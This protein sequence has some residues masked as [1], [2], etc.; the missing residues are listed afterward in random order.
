VRPTLR[1]VV[2]VLQVLEAGRALQLAE[3]LTG[4]PVGVRKLLDLAAAVREHETG[5]GG[6]LAPLLAR[7]GTAAAR[8]AEGA[9]EMSTFQ[10]EAC[11]AL[12]R[13]ATGRAR[14]SG[15]RM[16]RRLGPARTR[17]EPRR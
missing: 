1:S 5:R 11:L 4:L 17:P 6:P 15:R 12:M 7:L 2:F 16:P 10:G 8:A 14:L 9:R 3:D 13:F